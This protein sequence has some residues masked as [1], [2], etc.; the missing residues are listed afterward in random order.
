MDSTSGSSKVDCSEISGCVAAVDTQAT[1]NSG[2]KCNG[3]VGGD[4]EGD[5]LSEWYSDLDLLAIHS[6]GPPSSAKYV[7]ALKIGSTTRGI[8]TRSGPLLAAPYPFGIAGPTGDN[9]TS[10][11][12]YEFVCVELDVADLT[13]LI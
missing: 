13:V 6:S 5:L 2:F 7:E 11:P 12:I 9:E 10:F 1:S 3:E 8:P 4:D